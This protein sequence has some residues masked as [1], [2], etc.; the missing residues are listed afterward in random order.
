MGH[1][2]VSNG[3]PGEWFKVNV[4]WKSENFNQYNDL[5]KKIKRMLLY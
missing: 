2:S 3:I 5:S 4:I 1:Y